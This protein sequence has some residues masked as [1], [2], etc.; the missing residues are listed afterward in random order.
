MIKKN[1]TKILTNTLILGLFF[2]VLAGPAQKSY[3]DSKTFAETFKNTETITIESR[4]TA[5][6][7]QEYAL[8]YGTI[9]VYLS[10]I[11]D[12]SFTF[13]S[14]GGSWK[15]NSPQGT[16][17]EVEI[18][19]KEGGTWTPWTSLEEEVEA[20]EGD[21]WTKFAM[22]ATNGAE[23][24]Q[25]RFLLYGDGARTPVISDLSWTF[26]KA[27]NNIAMPNA[28]KPQYS[29]A[30]ELST[31][32]YLAAASAFTGVISRA[33]WGA[34]ESHRYL[35]D[36]TLEAD[37]VEIDPAVY[38]KYKDELKY[39]KTIKA[40]SKGDKYKWPLQYPEK[41]KKFVVHHTAT[42]SNLDNPK[43]AI[44]DIYYY[45]AVSRGWGDI[46]YNYI[47]DQGGKVYEG[48][49]GGE[50]VIGAHAGI[51]N[52]GS[53]GIAILGNYEQNPLP[54]NVV[55]SLSRLI[56]QKAKIHKI[57][58]AGVSTFRANTMPNV[59]GH[60]DI[61]STTCPGIYIYEKLPIIRTLAA[62]LMKE[63]K[64]FTKDY[65][66]QDKSELY[67]LQMKPDEVIDVTIKLE[68]IG[69]VDWD[70]ST[71][72]VA[73]RDDKMTKVISFPSAEGVSLAKMKEKKV[74][75]GEIAT[76]NFS[77]KASKKSDLVNMKIAPL[78]NG[79]K[80]IDEYI[81][82][83]IAVEQVDFRYEFVESK[84]PPK[85]MKAGEEFTG[86]V[87]L[88]NT[89]NVTW[90]KTGENIIVLATDHE[91]GRLSNLVSPPSKNLAFLTETEVKPGK[92]GTFAL[93]IKAPEKTGYYQ[94]YFTPVV[95]W[96]TWLS[97]SGMYFDTTVADISTTAEVVSKA[98]NTTWEIGKSYVVWI[99]MRNLGTET[100]TKDNLKLVFLK[101]KNLTVTG[102]ELG[103]KE[104]LA[105]E[106]GTISFV[107]KPGVDH[108]LGVKNIVIKAKLNDKL[109]TKKQINFEYTVKEKSAVTKPTP[110]PDKPSSD[111]ETAKGTE[112]DIRIKL[113]FSGNPKITSDKDF[114]IYSGDKLVVDLK[115]DQEAEVSYSN[116]K[117]KVTANK[118]TYTQTS[119]IRFISKK[120]DAIMKV[121]NYENRPAWNDKLNDNMYR[122]KLEVRY[123]DDKLVTINE[124]PLEQYI[125][126]LG[127]VSNT[128]S[129]EK[130]KAVMTAARTYAKY[131]MDVDQKFPG[132]PYNLDDDPNTSQKY[133]GYGLEK[134]SPNVTKA[135]EATKG[136]MV[137]Y[138]GKLIK[139]PY[140][141]QSD[142]VAT[143]SAKDVWKWD[144]T[145]YLVSVSDVFCSGDK[146]LGHGV[147]LSGCGAKGMA[148]AGYT[149]TQILLHYYTGVKVT[150]FY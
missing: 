103:A 21:I 59:F 150:D 39:S 18:R 42:T 58:P 99:K 68:N 63:K 138:K 19:F 60:K 124:L 25:Y 24:F 96:D 123:V 38:E 94:E 5:Q 34:D 106:S 91:K 64:K 110:V 114:S 126:G 145:P 139:T 32:T 89:G 141:N 6:I 104:V 8:P 23:S 148:E 27:G 95:N 146:F 70:S 85:A 36:N 26:I 84:Y 13:T 57:E 127:E 107:V 111:I 82:I 48:R 128:E 41:V 105:G 66:Y 133:L 144:N 92:T 40:D 147:G 79:K 2:S 120:D 67:Y 134:R 29:S 20:Q 30:A 81:T 143:K 62:E 131:Y 43:Q 77:V 3:E 61:M 73:D 52:N 46:G 51:G 135:V 37:L 86:W 55:G 31:A 119:P 116:S 108:A 140:F 83:P 78:V 1:L 75:P 98:P 35:S 130:I 122:G 65:D 47:V 11:K 80:K 4:R 10:E 17:V 142:G 125:K 54:E 117:Y 90:K 45:H 136:Q 76:F 93:K 109:I 129:T 149:Y 112:G 74:K 87:K 9:D 115:A 118:K 97:D 50:G 14:V 101:D 132:K 16:S 69:K 100:W 44:K 7:P 28:P 121:V 71:F 72:I 53:I 15:Q 88:K 113:S 22:A 12:S 137:T 49:Y 56:A 33:D 102:G